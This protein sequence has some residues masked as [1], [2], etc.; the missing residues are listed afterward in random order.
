MFMVGRL[1]PGVSFAA[2]N[3]FDARVGDHLAE[4][5]PAENSGRNVVMV[6]LSETNVPPVQRSLF[7]LVGTLMMAI[8][9]SGAADRLRK[10]GE[11]F[12][13]ASDATPARICDSAFA[14]CFALEGDPSVA[15]GKF[16][17]WI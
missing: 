3:N 13:G 12:V 11:S 15:D 2:A 1:K 8:V 7:V 16:A 10:C 5:Y 4:E 6:P 17:A 14:G 9:D